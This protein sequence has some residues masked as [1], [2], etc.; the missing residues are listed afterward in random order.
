MKKSKEMMRLDRDL[1]DNPELEKKFIE[2]MKEATGSGTYKN[3]T[4][5]IIQVAKSFGYEISMAEMERSIAAI[6]EVDP[7]EMEQVSG[8]DSDCD[9][10]WTTVGEDEYGHNYWCVTMWHCEMITMHTSTDRDNVYCFHNYLCNNYFLCSN[11]YHA[12]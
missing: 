7:E 11:V 2:A 9:A 3:D 5:V 4:E 8:G 10:L 6:E 12:R 1:K